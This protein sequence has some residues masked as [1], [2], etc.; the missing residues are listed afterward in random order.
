M[1][2]KELIEKLKSV[3]TTGGSGSY[4]KILEIVQEY[5]DSYM[6]EF[7]VSDV[8]DED[9][10]DD[11]VRREAEN[12]ARRVFCFLDGIE[13]WDDAYRINGYGN[14]ENLDEGY[15]SSVLSDLID[16][17]ENL[18]DD[19]EDDDEEDEEDDEE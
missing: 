19:D 2:K 3:H 8:I 12:G 1:T 13:W 15:L 10:L 4:Y 5:G 7:L 18:D 9:V 14:V 6:E 17:A 16:M 11:M